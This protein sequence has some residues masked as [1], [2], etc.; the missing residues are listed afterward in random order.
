MDKDIKMEIENIYNYNKPSDY[1]EKVFDRVLY[2]V[3]SDEFL[4]VFKIVN[5]EESGILKNKI[6]HIA[7]LCCDKSKKERERIS[8]YVK[9]NITDLRYPEYRKY[10]IEEEK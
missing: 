2:V 5:D 9:V 6:L 1:L 10:T 4:R 7:E 3:N 8:N